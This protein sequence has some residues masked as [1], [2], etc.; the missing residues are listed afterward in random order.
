MDEPPFNLAFI[1]ASVDITHYIFS[2]GLLNWI[3]YKYN[4]IAQLLC[5]L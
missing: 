3:L 1:N 5:I 4:F 2:I